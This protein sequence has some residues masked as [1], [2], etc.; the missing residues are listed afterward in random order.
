MNRFVEN[1]VKRY[2]ELEVCKNS[3][4]QTIACLIEVVKNDSTIF[5]A[6]NGGSASDAD[7]ICGEFL[8]GFMLKR[9]LTDAQKKSLIPFGEIGCDL[10]N[11]LQRGIKA[12]S[13]LSHP[14]FNSAFLNDVDGSMSYAQQ[15]F[16]LGRKG[17]VLIAI[18]TSGNAD[19]LRK[20]MILARS[21]G[22]KTILLTGERHGLC[23]EFADL[24]INAPA[25]E[26][27]KV[28]E[29]HLPIYH[30]I[31]QAVEDHFFGK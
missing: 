27:Y 7:H 19:N 12:I 3:I 25:C 4:E 15:L 31:C 2:P 6:G 20:A 24:V 11:K 17:D 18:S 28:Q 9:E 10:A 21:Q 30:A 23:E 5:I 13:L 8:K 22:I 14:G 29:Y 16:A 1:A 26:T